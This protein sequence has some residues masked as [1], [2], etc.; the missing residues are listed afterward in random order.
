MLLL[1]GSS[2]PVY[3]TPRKIGADNRRIDE[4]EIIILL[5][6]WYLTGGLG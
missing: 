6:W 5:W 1:W 3:H 2:Q 4:D